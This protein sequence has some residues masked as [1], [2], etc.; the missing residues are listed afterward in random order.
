MKNLLPEDLLTIVA[1]MRAR[2]CKSR[3]TIWQEV[4]D[5]T[6]PHPDK[7]IKRVRY[8]KAST[9]LKWQDDGVDTLAGRMILPNG[10]NKASSKIELSNE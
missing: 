5:G 3:T 7:I 8:W 10:S 9:L 6:F 1:V 2:G 4:R